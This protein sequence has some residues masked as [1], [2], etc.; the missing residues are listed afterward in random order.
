MH[1]NKVLPEQNTRED[2]PESAGKRRNV[3]LISLTSPDPVLAFFSQGVHELHVVTLDTSLSIP[4]LTGP[5]LRSVHV[6]DN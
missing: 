3:S 6:S 2:I 1:T 4:E 5:P